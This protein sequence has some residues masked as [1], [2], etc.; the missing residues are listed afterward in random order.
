MLFI[1]QPVVALPSTVI[2]RAGQVGEEMFILRNGRVNLCDSKVGKVCTLKGGSFFGEISII[3][4]VTRT[5]T[6]MAIT[7]CDMCVLRA[8]R[9]IE[10]RKIDIPKTQT[11]EYDLAW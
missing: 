8:D 5:C 10:V 3:A 11:E 9:L 7:S 4:R 2:Y 6:A 1:L